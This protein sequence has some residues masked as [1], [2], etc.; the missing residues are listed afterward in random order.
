[1]KRHLVTT[2]VYHHVWLD[3][4]NRYTAERLVTGLLYS[5]LPNIPNALHGLVEYK[6]TAR[7]MCTEIIKAEDLDEV[8]ELRHGDQ[9]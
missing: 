3:D 5:Q 7:V 2:T 9:Q 4:G 1:M 8:P 6:G